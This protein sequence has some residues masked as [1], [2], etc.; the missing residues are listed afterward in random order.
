MI[1]K[2]LIAGLL[3]VLIYAVLFVIQVWGGFIPAE[4]FAKITV[5]LIVFG[6]VDLIVIGTCYAI[7]ESEELKRWNHIG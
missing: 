7:K 5:T 2:F 1:K 4:T 3:L 6:L